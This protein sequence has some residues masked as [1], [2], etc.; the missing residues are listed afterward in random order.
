MV[1]SENCYLVYFL[2]PNLCA[3][4]CHPVPRAPLLTR[5]PKFWP[6]MCVLAIPTTYNHYQKFEISNKTKLDPPL[7]ENFETPL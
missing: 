7:N 4:T 6:K 1:K 5:E 3:I 2:V